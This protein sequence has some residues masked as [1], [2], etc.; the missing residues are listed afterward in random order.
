MGHEGVVGNEK[1]NCLSGSSKIKPE[2]RLT[3]G[4]D[5]LM[6]EIRVKESS[7]PR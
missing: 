3:N 6:V 2:A 4:F 5:S 7:M 1:Q